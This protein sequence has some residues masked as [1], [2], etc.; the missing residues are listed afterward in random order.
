MAVRAKAKARS[1]RRKEI[2]DLMS[3]Q[4]QK[5]AER[6]IRHELDEMDERADECYAY[7]TTIL[8]HNSPLI[9]EIVEQ[10]VETMRQMQGRPR[11]TVDGIAVNVEPQIVE[12]INRKIH[13]WLAVRLL[14]AAAQWDIQISGFVLPKK[15]CAVCGKKAK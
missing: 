7:A 1:K 10:M 6:K 5:A 9:R 3:P 14:A 15:M 12:N 2:V 13:T 4:A 11:F 8:Q